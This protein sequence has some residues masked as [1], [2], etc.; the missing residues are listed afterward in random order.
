VGATAQRLR[1]NSP[2]VTELSVSAN[3]TAPVLAA[4]KLAIMIQPAGPDTALVPLTPTLT[5]QVRDS[6]STL[7]PSYV[8]NMTVSIGSGPGVVS[9][10]TTRPVVN[11]I[12][13]FPDLTLNQVG[14]YR[15]AVSSGT[16]TPD[17]TESFVI[18]A[19]A[20]SSI[21]LVTGGGQTALVGA[22]LSTPITVRVR[23]A[24]NNVVRNAPVTFAVTAGGGSL[25][26]ASTVTD[27]LG[28]AAL[29]GWTLGLTVG[30]QSITATVNGV[31]PLQINATAEPLAPVIALNVVDGNVVGFQRSGEIRVRLFQP[32]PIGG[33]TVSV[34][35]DSTQ[36]LTIA[37][38]GSVSIPAGDTSATIAVSGINVGTADRKSVV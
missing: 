2:G 15:L 29:G 13:T 20:P 31:A 22:P 24:A 5:V 36:Y 23:D 8:G 14:S 18:I 37:A 1:F 30:T 21:A 17:T 4:T 7:V 26:G 16:L 27:S 34:V 33:L 25:L 9:G 28:I 10:T 3:V 6:T 38:P 32:A 12:A 35:S 19:G 11:G